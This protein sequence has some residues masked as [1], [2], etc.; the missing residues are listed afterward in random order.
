MIFQ[1]IRKTILKLSGL[2][3]TITKWE[4]MGLSNEKVFP[5]FT[6]NKSL[7]PKLVWYNYKI[8]LKFEGSC[9]KQENK[10]AFTLKYVVNFLLFIN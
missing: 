9:L 7:S 8:I 2:P 3:D 6:I 4:S 1:P 5:P 10:A